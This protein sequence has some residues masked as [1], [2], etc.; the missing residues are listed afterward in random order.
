MRV[1]DKGRAYATLTGLLLDEY[2]KEREV[3]KAREELVPV[4]MRI[5][6]GGDIPMKD[7]LDF[8]KREL[9]DSDGHSIRDLRHRLGD[10]IETQAK[11]LSEARSSLEHAE[12]IR[13]FEQSIQDDYRDLRDALKSH[14]V[15]ALGSKEVLMSIVA[16]VGTIAATALHMP[17]AAAEAVSLTGSV[18]ALGGLFSTR[19]KLAEKRRGI[20]KDHPSA[21]IYEALGG[22]RW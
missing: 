17:L 3:D 5:V 1:T 8:R 11:Q 16:G 4:P 13:E 15:Q 22:L 19:S 14:L 9:A 20:L 10:K 21:Y 6:A 12:I 18:V 2:N 7:L